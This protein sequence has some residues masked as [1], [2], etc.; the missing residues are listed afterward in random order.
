[1][2]YLKHYINHKEQF[3]SKVNEN[4]DEFP[5]EIKDEKGVKDWLKWSQ[6]KTPD[7]TE[8]KLTMDFLDHYH[9][10]EKIKDEEKKMIE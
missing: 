1:M 9:H 5:M 2:K 3:I 4:L 7:K 6:N 8:K 10:S